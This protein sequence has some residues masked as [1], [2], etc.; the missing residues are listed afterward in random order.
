MTRRFAA[1]LPGWEFDAVD[2]SPAMLALAPPHPRI[3]F[4]TGY[5]PGVKL[6]RPRYDLILSSS[7]LHHLH[8]PAGL[9]ETVRQCGLPGTLVFVVD[10]RRPDSAAELERIFRENVG[11]APEVLQRDYRASLHAAFT[12][13][14]VEAQLA[15]AGLTQ[16]PVREITDRHWMVA[17]II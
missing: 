7:F 8:N 10:L 12:V 6:P 11:A 13:A 9:W 16:L 2:G 1:I 5:I 14:E 4:H 17:G 15:A 3:R